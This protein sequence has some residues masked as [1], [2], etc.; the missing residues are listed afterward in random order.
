MGWTLSPSPC[1]KVRKRGTAALPFTNS[2]V[3]DFA[4]VGAG[5]DGLFAV[6]ANS[7]VITFLGSSFPRGRPLVGA[8]AGAP[9]GSRF[10]S[11][12]SFPRGLV[13]LSLHPWRSASRGRLRLGVSSIP[14]ADP[15]AL[16]S[17]VLSSDLGF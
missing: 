1:L 13:A 9:M 12:A 3:W 5:V 4:L 2:L 10:G 17:A 15:N 16:I 8:S 14:G 6:A 11:A 7:G